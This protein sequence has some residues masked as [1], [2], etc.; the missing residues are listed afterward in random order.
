VNDSDFVGLCQLIQRSVAQTRPEQSSA[1][2]YNG[3]AV[4]VSKVRVRYT[5]WFASAGLGICGKNEASM[6]PA[7][8]NELERSH[9]VQGRES[10]MI[11][12]Q[13]FGVYVVS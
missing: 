4:G 6:E 11:G 2:Q 8:A 5:V 7:V 10:V 1:E 12:E 3:T 9:S 13:C